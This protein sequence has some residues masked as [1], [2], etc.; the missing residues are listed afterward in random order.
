MLHKFTIAVYISWLYSLTPTWSR[1]L[2]CRPA[3]RRN[4]SYVKKRRLSGFSAPSLYAWLIDLTG[5]ALLDANSD[6]STSRTYIRSLATGNLAIN[7][8]QRHMLFVNLPSWTLASLLAKMGFNALCIIDAML[9]QPSQR[10]SCQQLLNFVLEPSSL[11][12][13]WYQADT[14]AATFC[15][16]KY[17]CPECD[18]KCWWQHSKGWSKSVGKVEVAP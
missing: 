14:Y 2:P 5:N 18:N 1:S 17:F 8:V 15:S 6:Y 7:R 12:Y 9:L 13:N 16:V 3:F 11:M 4:F 10:L